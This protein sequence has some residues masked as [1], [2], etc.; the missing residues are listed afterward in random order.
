[1]TPQSSDAASGRRA[2][3]LG[4]LARFVRRPRWPVTLYAILIIAAVAVAIFVAY[5]TGV[6]N[7]VF[8][9]GPAVNAAT[10]YVAAVREQRYTAAYALL[11]P[12]LRSKESEQSYAAQTRA[13][14]ASDGGI[15][16]VAV[17]SQKQDGS[18]TVVQ[19]RITR[20]SRGTFTA[21]FAVEKSHGVWLI[22]GADD[23]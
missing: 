19:L 2:T 4:A 14:D 22:T 16:G 6:F 7:Q 23:L 20:A 12:D 21:H 15:T 1:M 3:V 10:A 17:V 18:V 11:A 9:R 5:D 8:T 13:I